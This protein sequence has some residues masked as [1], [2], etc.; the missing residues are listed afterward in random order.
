MLTELLPPLVRTDAPFLDVPRVDALG[1]VWVEPVLSV[2]VAYL[3]ITDD[4][5]LRQPSYRG[6]RSDS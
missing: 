6:V 3:R 2:D 1:T 5:R 4:G